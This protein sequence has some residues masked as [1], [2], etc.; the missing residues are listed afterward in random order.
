MGEDRPMNLR[1]YQEAAAAFLAARLA[2]ALVV[3]PAGGGKTHIAA[4]ALARRA[5]EW[6]NVGWACHTREQADQGRAALA[7]HGVRAVWVRC[8]AGLSAEDVAGLDFLILDEC[9][10]LPAD[11]WHRIADACR[12]A[13][14]GLTA[15]P[16]SGD[17]DRDAFF[18]A[19]WAGAVHTVPRAE[20]MA[21]GHLAA[22]VVRILDLDTP[23]EFDSTIKAVAE[24]EAIKGARRWPG[25][26]PEEL[27]RRAQWRATQEFLIENPVRNAAVVR[28]AP[29]QV[30]AG[31]SVLVLVAEIEAGERLAAQIPGSALVHSK[32]GAKKRREIIAAFRDGGL[33]V[34]LATSLADEGLDVP[35]AGVLI[36]ATVGRSARLIEQRSGRVMRPFAGKTEGVVYDFADRGASLAHNQHRSRLSTY[37]RLGYRV[38]AVA[39]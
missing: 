10:H 25:L 8:V 17:P 4:S 37:R 20:I 36:L 1:P 19:F 35:R 26:D 22:G 29:E 33:G 14:W 31:A 30:A 34:M 12:G 39:L 38:E 23:G 6:D 27:F 11:S 16:K 15:T 32:V 13:V 28:I 21:G 3:C 7:A 9:H 24:L 18:R 5:S 2:R